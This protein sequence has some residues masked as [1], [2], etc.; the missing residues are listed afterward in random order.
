MSYGAGQA[1][2][3]VFDTLVTSWMNQQAREDEKR[4]QEAKRRAVNTQLANANVTFDQTQDFLNDY[5]QGRIKLADDSMVKQYKDL[6]TSYEPQV[7]D[8][9]EFSYNKT[10]DDFLNPEAEKIAQLAGLQTQSDLAGQGAAKGT[11]AL[12]SLGYSRVK[13]AEDLYKDAQAQYNAD[14]SQAYT[15]YNDYIKNMQHKLDTISQ[16]QLA[17]IQMLGGAIENEQTQQ[18]D[19]MSDLLGLIRDKTSTNINATL[20]AF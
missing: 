3:G 7:Y 18:S 6:M 9:D 1:A 8:F 11:G 20:G 10:V 5:N 4:L 2:A 16:G 19:Y 14:R 13:A 12:A 15:E 17:K